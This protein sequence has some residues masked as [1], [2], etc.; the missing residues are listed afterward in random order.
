MKIFKRLICKTFRRSPGTQIG[1]KPVV[2]AI[3]ITEVKNEQDII[4]PFLR[5]NR[6][7]F[8]AM[9]IL[10]NGSSDRTREIAFS[11]AQELGGVFVADLPSFDYLQSKTMTTALKHI[12]AAFF[13][14]FICFLDADEF[15]G[16]SDRDQFLQAMSV[17]PV[18]TTSVHPWQTFLPDPNAPNG[19]ST[20][21]L[22]RLTYRRR[23]E[24]PQHSKVFLRM[25]GAFDPDLVVRR[26]AH[27][28]ASACDEKLPILPMPGLP[29]RHFPVR[30]SA[31]VLSKG[32]LGWL[33]NL[34]ADP[35]LA[36]H[37]TT[38]KIPSYQWKRLYSVAQSGQV[39]LTSA[40]LSDEAM[41]YAQRVVPASFA[42]N[43]E[44]ADNHLNLHRAYS[45][46][47]SDDYYRT[48]AT[49]VIRSGKRPPVFTI[50]PPQNTGPTKS[51]VATASFR[52]WQS[53]QTHFDAAPIQ[54]FAQRHRPSSVFDVGCGKGLY[55]RFLRDLGV[56]DVFGVD[57]A[58]QSETVL[59]SEDYAKAD[60][61]IPFEAGRRF[62]VVFCLEVAN[63]LHPDT[64]DTLFN[65]VSN[66]ATT[67]IL[68]S[69]AEPGQVGNGP[70]NGRTMPDVLAMW[71]NR[72]WVPD[73]IETL[74]FRALATLSWLRRNVVI[75]KRAPATADDGATEDDGATDALCAIAALK[76]TWYSQQPGIRHYAFE[77]P[78]PAGRAA[79]GK[80]LPNPL[81]PAP[82]AA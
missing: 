46:G 35:K 74:G 80:V 49:S 7:Y 6:N 29:I 33:A 60:L 52:D 43:A 20:D 37:A 34:A 31:Q 27:S 5:T 66:H 69:M 76:Y 47:Q 41:V 10:D 78:Y 75:L 50:T 56:K 2:R 59:A 22:S 42:D 48:V 44:R 71:R 15:I 3:C 30:N 23:T 72:G 24:N 67:T 8:D 13:A 21:P 55:L 65:T 61:Q 26:G 38:A 4:E 32:V 70:I 68:F 62:D 57:R 17:V 18:G 53:Q 82:P 11:C 39:P 79:Y 9:I 36:A 63:H 81:A 25:G 64:T 73:L 77:D 12:Q 54:D 1:G 40:Q 58:E 14:D 45:D 16:A 51:D 28:I 19:P